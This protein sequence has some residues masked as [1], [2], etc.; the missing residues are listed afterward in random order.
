MTQLISRRGALVVQRLVLVMFGATASCGDDSVQWP[1]LADAGGQVD[2]TLPATAAAGIDGGGTTSAKP[3]R[4]T[5][6][7]S[8]DA[9][10]PTNSD[11]HV[12]AGGIA[13]TSNAGV[14][15]GSA[16]PSG[17]AQPSAPAGSGSLS[18]LPGLPGLPSINI[19]IPT[20]GS[21]PNLDDGGVIQLTNEQ[22]L[23]V[24]DCGTRLASCEVA[25]SAEQSVCLDMFSSCLRDSAIGDEAPVAACGTHFSACILHDPLDYAECLS[26]LTRCIGAGTTQ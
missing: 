9:G 3:P 19:A 11:P 14:S 20:V 15:G 1:D 8:V 25:R 4:P 26:E 22:A 23:A 24:A 17:N 2:A 13:A 12:G 10:T 16:A 18:G 5:A 21:I 6:Q 7:G